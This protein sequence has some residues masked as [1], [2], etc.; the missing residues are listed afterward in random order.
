MYKL[1]LS[2]IASLLLVLTPPVE[3]KV[4]AKGKARAE[5]TASAG[6]ARKHIVIKSRAHRR[7]IALRPAA[8]AAIPWCGA[9]S[10]SVANAAGVPARHRCRLPART[11]APER[12]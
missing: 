11:G 3:A 1:V 8:E 2:V 12:W 6:K 7:E 10:W 9:Q 4:K 5:R